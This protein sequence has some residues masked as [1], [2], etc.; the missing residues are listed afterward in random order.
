MIQR[1]ELRGMISALVAVRVVCHVYSEPGPLP[2]AH[3]P[4][5]FSVPFSR[6]S[7]ALSASVATHSPPHH[8]DHLASC[9]RT[10]PC[11]PLDS[12]SDFQGP[13]AGI[14]STSLRDDQASMHLWLT[15]KTFD[16]IDLLR[17]PRNRFLHSAVGRPPYFQS[18]PS[19][20]RQAYRL[21]PL[22]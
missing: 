7:T 15:L 1:L 16:N 19:L 4:L 17:E 20:R 3:C 14:A 18:Q 22:A 5:Q 10:A 8:H 6:R 12:S 13:S 9:L 21:I 11:I 2:T